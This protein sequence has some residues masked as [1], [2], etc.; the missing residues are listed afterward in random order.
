[1]VGEESVAQ[2]LFFTHIF[3]RLGHNLPQK[4]D[5]FTTPERSTP[6]SSGTMD[7]NPVLGL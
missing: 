6:G 2:E 4:H 3:Y 5:T 7:M 1:M